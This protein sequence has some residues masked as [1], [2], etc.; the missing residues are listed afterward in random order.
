MIRSQSSIFRITCKT[1]SPCVYGE[2]VRGKKNR[3]LQSRGAAEQFYAE[4]RFFVA[5]N[6]DFTGL[7]EFLTSK[8]RRFDRWA[9][10]AAAS[11]VLSGPLAGLDFRGMNMRQCLAQFVQRLRYLY[12]RGRGYDVHVDGGARAQA[13]SGPLQSGG[14][15]VGRHTI[16]TS[17]VTVLSHKLIPRSRRGGMWARRRIRTLEI[18]ASSASAR[19][20]SGACELGTRLWWVRVQSSRA[21]SRRIP[22]LPGNP[23]KIIRQESRWRG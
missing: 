7:Q 15:H 12:Y 22:W 11:G 8:V 20:S 17:G 19:S 6:L 23:A 18:F 21:M 4:D 14:M 3:D 1:A 16:L 10:Y 2:Y 9:I 13:Q 5:D